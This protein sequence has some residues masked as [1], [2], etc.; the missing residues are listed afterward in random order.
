MMD[1]LLNVALA[2]IAPVWLNKN[3]TIDKVETTILEAANKGSE[4]VVFGEALCRVIHFG[5]R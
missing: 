1:H 5:W 2:Q 3:A 4:L